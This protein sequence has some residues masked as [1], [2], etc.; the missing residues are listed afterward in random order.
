MAPCNASSGVKPNKVQ[1]MFIIKRKDKTG[2]DPGLQSLAMAIGTPN[3]RRRCMGGCLVSLRQK[4]APG[5]ITATVPE[6]AMTLAS[7][8]LR[9]SR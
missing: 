5:R 2:A 4:N 6:M 1:A 7:A 3:S 8:S 9:Y